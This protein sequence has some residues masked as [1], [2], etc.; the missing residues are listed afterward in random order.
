MMQTMKPVS[1]GNRIVHNVG[2]II[3]LVSFGML[4]ATLMMG[5]AIYRLQAPVWPPQ[6]MIRPSLLL[7]ILSTSAIFFSSMAYHWF[8]KNIIVFLN[9]III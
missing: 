4:F 8:E 2:M 9:C 6:G 7:P 1:A 3:T 5:F